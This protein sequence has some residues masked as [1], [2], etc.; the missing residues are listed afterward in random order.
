MT[1]ANT[2]FGTGSTGH[3]QMNDDSMADDTNQA[4]PTPAPVFGSSPFGQQGNPPA[5]PFGA[6]SIQPGGMFQFG[7]Q[8]QGSAPQNPAFPPG[9]SLEFQ[10]G[11]FSLGS[12]GAGGDKS[13][14]R[15]IKVK[16]GPKKR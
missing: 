7:G 8:E 3:D 1:N 2:G 14:R 11:G 12:G 6:P 15:V 9:G 13:S 16:R 10:S 4:A 5:A